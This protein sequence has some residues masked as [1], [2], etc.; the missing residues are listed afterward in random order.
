MAEIQFG[1]FYL[2]LDNRWQRC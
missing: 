1:D 2:K